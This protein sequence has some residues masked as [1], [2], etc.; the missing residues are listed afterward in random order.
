MKL[1]SPIQH[2][3][4]IPPQNIEA[5]MATLGAMLMS[6]SVISEVLD[7][8]DE[9]SFY[10][11]EHQIIFNCIF[12]LFDERKKID[13][14]TASEY[15]NKK[16]V[17]ERVGGATYLTTLTDFVPTAANAVHYA[18]I[19]KEKSILRSLINSATEIAGS[20]YKGEEEVSTILDRAEKLIFAIS[21]KRVESGYVH[22]KDIIKD[23]IEL[24]ESLYHKK[25]HVTG[26]PTGF[27]DVD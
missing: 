13:I 9:A 3:D 4:K 21:D 8:V 27:K 26:I 22:I 17:L 5:E 24:I 20:V 16:K 1:D 6:E 18:R 19:I 10:K 15:L 2:I 23:G 12:A 14:L 11:Q 7:L 25:S